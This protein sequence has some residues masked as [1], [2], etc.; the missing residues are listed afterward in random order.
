MDGCKQSKAITLTTKKVAKWGTQ[1]K[2]ATIKEWNIMDNS[3]QPGTVSGTVCNHG[4]YY[5]I[6]S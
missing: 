2:V 6:T 4:L 5:P 3:T 1:K